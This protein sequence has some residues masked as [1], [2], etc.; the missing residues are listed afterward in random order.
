VSLLEKV[1]SETGGSEIEPGKRL[2]RVGDDRGLSLFERLN[3]RLHRFAWRTPIHKLRLRGRVPLKLVAVPKDPIAGDKAAGEALLHGAFRHGGTEVPVEGLDFATLG[4]PEDFSAYLQSFAW[5]RDLSAAATRERGAKL[6]EGI[7]RKWLA[8]HAEQ[9]SEPAWRSD[10]WGR[11]ILFWTAYAP[12]ILS[13]PD[14]VYRSRVLYALARGA[15][16]LERSAD[17]ALHGLPRIV[18]WS[19]VIVAALVVQG[20]P[21]RL[22][23]G[24]AGLMRALGLSLHDDGGLVSRSPTEQLALV[25]T[26][27]QLRAAY[28]A[29]RRDVPE[30]LSEALA[31]A[32]GALL[33]VTLGDDALSSWQGGNMAGS[34]R[35]AAAVDGAGLEVRPLRQARGW[36][37]QRVQGKTT[38]LV[39]DAAPPPPPRA[40]V[41]ACASTLA[42]ELS[43]GPNRLVINCGGV[44][45]SKGAL[46][47]GL[48]H[49]LRTT[50]AH[51][52]LTLG[53]RNS[54]AIHDD[55]SLGRG[56][57]EVELVRDD[58]AGIGRVEA[59]HD[60]YVRRFGLVHERRLNLSADGRQLAGEDRLIGSGRRRRSEPVPFAVRFHLAP[61][62]EV[63]STADGQGALLRQRGSV[64]QFRCRGGRLSAEDSLWVDGE[65]RPR[66]TYQLVITGESPP[67]GMTISWELIRVS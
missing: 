40:L 45:E 25:E 57:G 52:T 15:R 33:A 28:S 65:A 2:I 9:V 39:F 38:V 59:S 32:V 61:A 23:S 24:E 6:A 37:Y 18:A 36:G 47:A 50:A 1:E 44:G 12:Y 11:R 42:F 5:L 22:K 55:G 21:A 3:Y 8:V 43:D 41:G 19:G 7:M 51:S 29:A 26:L 66:A 56:V 63:T 48:A 60:G 20:G 13:S 4:L 54:T 64:W 30:W 16:H 58:T 62:V 49:A 53:D 34:R 35:I 14:P 17:K 10:L 46:P 67:E 27:G 31:S